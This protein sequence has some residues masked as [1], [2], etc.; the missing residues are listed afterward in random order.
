MC[1]GTKRQRGIVLCT[2]SFS[3]VDVVT[4]INILMLVFEIS[5]EMFLH[6]GKPRIYIRGKD[7]DKIR[8]LIV[9]HMSTHFMYKIN[10]GV[11]RLT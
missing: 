2:D 1:D 5:P 8:H 6:S 3:Y 9:P 11:K 4:L 10:H 7:L